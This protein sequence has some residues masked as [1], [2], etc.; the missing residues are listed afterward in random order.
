MQ[1]FVTLQFILRF[2]DA[3]GGNEDNG[4]L[5]VE[6]CVLHQFLQTRD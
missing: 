6:L 4:L 5:N 2:E 3:V 1:A